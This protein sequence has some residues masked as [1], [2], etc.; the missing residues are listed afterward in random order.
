MCKHSGGRRGP[1]RGSPPPSPAA[2]AGLCP[3]AGGNR[4][5]TSPSLLPVGGQI[6]LPFAADVFLADLNGSAGVVEDCSSHPGSWGCSRL[7]WA[8][9]C[10]SPP[11]LQPPVR[12]H[13]GRGPSAS[14]RL[15]CSSEAPPEPHAG[16]HQPQMGAGLPPGPGQVR[17]TMP[18]CSPLPC[19]GMSEPELLCP[20]PGLALSPQARLRAGAE[21]RAVP[22]ALPAGMAGPRRLP[23]T[24]AGRLRRL[25]TLGRARP[26]C[27]GGGSPASPLRPP[28][29]FPPPFLH[30]YF[31]LLRRTAAAPDSKGRRGETV[32]DQKK[33]TNQPPKPTDTP[34]PNRNHPKSGDWALSGAGGGGGR[35]GQCKV[36][37]GW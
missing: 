2:A 32:V 27:G 1:A 33:K 4:A 5:S 19:L 26:L 30:R 24:A 16:L 21:A 10:R 13:G 37:C 28:H 18:K 15:H 6:R 12:A 7:G 17:R 9:G 31:A 14:R 3:S 22:L 34:K 36:W 8:L 23:A 29:P 20:P 35:V 11:P 25:R